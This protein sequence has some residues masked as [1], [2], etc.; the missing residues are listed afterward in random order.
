MPAG[1]SLALAFLIF[2][3]WLGYEEIIG[4]EA[5]ARMSLAI[6]SGI[7]VSVWWAVTPRLV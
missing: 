5:C 3:L 7:E 6:A 4:T 2:V 1:V